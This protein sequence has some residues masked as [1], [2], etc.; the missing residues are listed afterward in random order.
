M[1]IK[2][3]CVVKYLKHDYKDVALA[4][5]MLLIAGSICY[6]I[7]FGLPIII[8]KTPHL[9]AYDVLN[10]FSGLIVISFTIGVAIF[11]DNKSF[12]LSA[13]DDNGCKTVGKTIGGVECAFIPAG[14]CVTILYV[15][16]SVIRVL[17]STYEDPLISFI[18][19]CVLLAIFVPIGCAIARCKE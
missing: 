5:T 18:V 11:W 16:Y 19:C 10:I 8:S 6:G 12:E 14:L 1:K 15:T 13:Y 3:D 7:I 17:M 2:T 9:S 4:I